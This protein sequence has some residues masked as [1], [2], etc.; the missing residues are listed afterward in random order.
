MTASS[1]V[2]VQGPLYGVSFRPRGT[3]VLRL[4][5]NAARRAVGLEAVPTTRAAEWV[6]CEKLRPDPWLL[7]VE[8]KAPCPTT[9]ALGAAGR[10]SPV[11]AAGLLPA[12]RPLRAQAVAP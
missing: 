2:I 9:R 3:P 5:G 12:A 10:I 11:A 7:G 1:L 4:F 8:V 6:P